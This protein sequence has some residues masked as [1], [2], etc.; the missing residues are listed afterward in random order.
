[1]GMNKAPRYTPNQV[2]KKAIR[3]ECSPDAYLIS[4]AIVLAAIVIIGGYMGYQEYTKGQ[5]VDAIAKYGQALAK[6]LA[7]G[8]GSFGK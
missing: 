3:G 5:I 1:M 6:G 8:L 4:F 7:K 2:E